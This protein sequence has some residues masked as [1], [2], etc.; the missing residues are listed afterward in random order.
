MWILLQKLIGKCVCLCVFFQLP[1]L[2]VMQS[3]LSFCYVQLF[4]TKIA[5]FLVC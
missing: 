1:P 2:L 5:S 4:V 3:T